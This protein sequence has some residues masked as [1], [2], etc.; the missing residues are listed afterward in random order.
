[1][2]GSSLPGRKWNG[3]MKIVSRRETKASGIIWYNTQRNEE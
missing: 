2:K 1:M 3:E